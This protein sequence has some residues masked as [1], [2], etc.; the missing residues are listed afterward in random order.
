ME[1]WCQNTSA[2]GTNNFAESFHASLARRNI[3]CHPG[4]HVFLRRMIRIIKE[5]KTELDVER[6]NPKI[7]RSGK[8]YSERR[9]TL[10]IENYLRGPPLALELDDF[11]REIFRVL[12]ERHM[13]EDMFEEDKSNDGEDSSE[14]PMEFVDEE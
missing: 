13:D 7:K 9:T 5:T 11:L 8:D 1:L 12:H 2:F 6:Q 3:P 14:V 10:L 4:F